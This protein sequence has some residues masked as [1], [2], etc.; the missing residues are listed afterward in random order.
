MRCLSVW[1]ALVV[2]PACA[3]AG[4]P[5]RDGGGGGF[6]TILTLDV[7]MDVEERDGG[8][9]DAPSELDAPDE[10]DVPGDLDGGADAPAPLDAPMPIDAP[11][12]VPRPDAPLPVSCTAAT[13]GAVC[14]GRPCVDGYCCDATCSTPC[15]SCGIAGREGVC[16][17]AT[18][19][20]CDDGDGCTFGERCVASGACSGG[21]PIS[22]D[23]MD[24]ACRDFTCN[25]TATCGSAP[26]PVG[27]PC[28][29]GN[30]GTMEDACRADGSCAGVIAPC[31]L[32][33]DACTTGA[34]TRDRC[35]N[36]RIVGRAEAALAAGYR[37]TGTTCTASNR[38]DDC[39]WDAGNDH[40]YRLWMRTGET[41]TA[42]VTN[43]ATCFD[44]WSITLKV[45]ESTGCADVTCGRDVWCEDH[46]DLGDTYPY[47]AT[48]DGWVVLVVDG[49]TAFDDEG[50]YTLTVRLT[51]CAAPGCGC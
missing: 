27:T 25:G 35:A 18:G 44:S 29:D 5:D 12:D 41:M 1:L 33:A 22:C 45:Y 24:T 47:T 17:V 11:I 13:A 28:D 14:G 32:P 4:R 23:G 30:A 39:S 38:F 2:V 49:S 48:H 42:S 19:I 46:V 7:S 16:T 3:S 21:T 50:E 10:L 6:D 8:G 20:G 31:T 51:G 36:A 37:V 15:D 43:R 9:L 34:Q 40:A 26:R